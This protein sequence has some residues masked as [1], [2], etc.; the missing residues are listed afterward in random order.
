M[1]VTG[2]RTIQIVIQLNGFDTADEHKQHGFH[3]HEYG[4]IDKGCEGAGGHYNPKGAIH[5]SPL[6]D[7]DQR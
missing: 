5:G 2:G 3:I 1:Q 7:I 6:D 4:T